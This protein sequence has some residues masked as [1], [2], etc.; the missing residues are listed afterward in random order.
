MLIGIQDDRLTTKEKRRLLVKSP[1]VSELPVK[2]HNHF[3][4]IEFPFRF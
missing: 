3:D 4:F 1:R 2:L